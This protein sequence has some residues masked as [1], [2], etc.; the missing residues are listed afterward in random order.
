MKKILVTGSGGFLGKNL[1]F[2]LKEKGF[3]LV[4]FDKE[5]SIQDLESSISKVDLIYHLAGVNRPEEEKEFLEGNYLLTKKIIDLLKSKGIKIPI[6]YSSSIQVEFDN[7]YGNSKRLAEEELIR[8]SEEN[9]TLLFIYRLSNLFGKG[10]KPNYNSVVATFCYNLSR[11]LPISIS[12]EKKEISLSYVDE[13]IN[14]FINCIGKLNEKDNKD[15]IIFFDKMYKITLRD[16]VNKIRDFKEMR[17]EIHVPK[18]SDNL[19]KYLYSTYLSYLPQNTFSIPLVSHK[20]E[21]GSFTEFIKT[22]DSGQISV[23]TSKPGITRGNHYHNTKTERFFVL[24][25]KASIKFRNIFE[26]KII[27]YLV[28]EDD[29]KIVDIP[30]G[31]AHNITNISDKEMIL[32]IWANEEFDSKNPDTYPHK[33]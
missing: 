7:P 12:D 32:L 18:F 6:V 8:Y 29:P 2:A 33:V 9:K 30:P 22:F 21:R 10:A 4:Y 27:E 3:S 19:T 1:C 13:V 17:N 23:S 25:G 5:N 15:K 14:E 28:S 24:K 26:N 16:L 31:Y 11:D 20:D